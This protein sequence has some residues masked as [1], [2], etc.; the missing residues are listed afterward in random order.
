MRSA[1]PLLATFT[2][3]L[4]V[5]AIGVGAVASRT[6]ADVPPPPPP[7]PVP[8]PSPTPTPA[9]AP[10]PAPVLAKG[11]KMVLDRLAHDY[12]VVRQTE[13]HE[14]TFTITNAGD[15][16]LHPI[17]RGECSCVQAKLSRNEVPPGETATLTVTFET[18]RFVGPMT[19][20]L[21]VRSDDP[22]AAEV[23][24]TLKVDISAGVVLQP[25]NFFFNMV[26][27][28]TKPTSTIEV[29]WKEGVGQPFKL[30]GVDATGMTPSTVK[31]EF[32]V[33]PF[34]AAPWKGYRVTMSFP[35]P[36]PVGLVSGTAVIRTDDERTPKVQALIGGAISAKVNVALLKPSFGVVTEGKAANL[37]VHVRPFEPKIVLGNVSAR[38]RT[39]A[40]KVAV[41]PD[42]T[43]PGE[44]NLELELPADTK[45]GAVED[46][47]E[48]RTEVPGE[49]LVELPV[50]A[51]VAPPSPPK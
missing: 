20:A 17:A 32:T 37:V 23:P 15:A 7:A 44:F 4:A 18:Y 39:G 3:A 46:V 5:A 14:T 38:S 30:L 43:M 47:V 41:K 25:Q 9:P 48:L 2:L 21:R 51:S 26:L 19:K 8:A 11:P 36:P 22:E 29:K 1:R 27:T 35:E 12:G 6:H 28:G 50:T 33:E 10:A 24:V 31:P 16:P 13:K 45:A 34:E 49:E 42:P 40:V